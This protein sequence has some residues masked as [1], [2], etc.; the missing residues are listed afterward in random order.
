V[1]LEIEESLA[2]LS[3]D[4]VCT[5][6]TKHI[7]EDNLHSMV[8]EDIQCDLNKEDKQEYSDPIEI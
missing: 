5:P 6:Q 2:C 3:T 7:E 1:E 8:E 4:P